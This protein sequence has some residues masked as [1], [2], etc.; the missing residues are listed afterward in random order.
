MNA[1]LR[2]QGIVTLREVEADEAT[3]GA[4]VVLVEANTKEVRAEA[5]ETVIEEVEADE[6]AEAG[7]E[8][9]RLVDVDSQQDAAA[10]K[11]GQ[12]SRRSSAGTG[13]V[14]PRGHGCPS[15]RNPKLQ[16]TREMPA[17]CEKPSRKLTRGLDSMDHLRESFHCLT[18]HRP[19][20]GSLRRADE[21]LSEGKSS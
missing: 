20:A 14:T 17:P 15:R 2:R 13:M 1:W 10:L 6:V 3:S 19:A 4:V 9:P 18:L 12:G 16:P 5:M 11:G 21:L 8:A 7:A